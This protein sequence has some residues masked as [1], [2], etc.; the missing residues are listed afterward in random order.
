MQLKVNYDDITNWKFQVHAFR[1]GI[2]IS[3]T[4]QNLKLFCLIKWTGIFRFMPFLMILAWKATVT[5][6]ILN[7]FVPFSSILVVVVGSIANTTQ[8][9]IK[10]VLKCIVAPKIWLFIHISTYGHTYGHTNAFKWFCHSQTYIYTHI[11]K[12]V[13]WCTFSSTH[14]SPLIC[15]AIPH[16]HTKQMCDL[17]ANTNVVCLFNWK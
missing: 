17:K 13:M 2:S 1:N 15:K 12:Y 11:G 16:P 9:C 6:K 7:C 8:K 14:A 5:T 10:T 3:V 4:K